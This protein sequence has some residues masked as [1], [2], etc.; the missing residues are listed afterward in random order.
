MAR[1]LASARFWVFAGDISEFRHWLLV[2]NP[3]FFVVNSSTFSH[4]DLLLQTLKTHQQ[5]QL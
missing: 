3:S 5:V 4:I 1:R 2:H